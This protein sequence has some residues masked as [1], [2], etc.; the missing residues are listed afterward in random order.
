MKRYKKQQKAVIDNSLNESKL[1]KNKNRNFLNNIIFNF[2]SI[3]FKNKDIISGEE[4]VEYGILTRESKNILLNL[5]KFRQLNNIYYIWDY[6]KEFKKLIFSFKYNKKI[7]LA[8]LIAE[9]IKEEFYFVLEKEKIDFIVSVPINKKR[10]NERGFNQVDEI[11]KNLDINFV[12]LKRDKNTK[13]MHEILDEK[14]REENVKGSFKVN[15]NIDFSNKN[16]LLVD[17]IVTTGATLREIKSSILNNLNEKNREKTK[18][19][20]FCLATAKEIKIN[21]GE[22]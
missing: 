13:K 4:L 15:K 5:K 21:K 10:L 16:I 20:V 11:L 7:K 3:I 2:K 12:K 22:I 9:L 18:I 1:D 14:L 6:N 19:I 8:K 17:D